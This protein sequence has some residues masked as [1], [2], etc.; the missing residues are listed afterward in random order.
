M[1]VASILSIILVS[2][3]APAF[4]DDADLKKQVDQIGTAYVESFNKQDV[5]GIAALFATNAI[6][7]NPLGAQTD[8]VKFV[9][10]LFKAGVNHIEAKVDQVWLLESDTGIGMG[11]AKYTGKS[12]SGAPI[13][14]TN[15]WT[16][17]HVQDGGKWKVR[18]LSGIPK[19]PPTK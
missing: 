14:A 16:A 7:V 11:Q 15:F 3:S 4:A 5:A 17:T 1:R 19:P 9:E 2:F 18:M 8:I 12:Q 6:V 10:G 13:E